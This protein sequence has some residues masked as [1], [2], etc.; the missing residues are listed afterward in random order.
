MG[1]EMQLWGG[2]MPRDKSVSGLCDRDLLVVLPVVHRDSRDCLLTTLVWDWGEPGERDLAEH[3]D[4]ERGDLEC[5]D[6]EWERDREE[7][8]EPGVEP[9][10]PR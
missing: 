9:R 1:G 2:A 8:R 4:R 5:G 3:G 10:K 7:E 6:W